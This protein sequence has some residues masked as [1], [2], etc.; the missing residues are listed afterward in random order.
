MFFLSK[1]H[2]ACALL[3]FVPA[4]F[5]GENNQNA[6]SSSGFFSCI[7][8]GHL[9]MQ[10]GY[11]WSHQGKS[12][13]INIEGLIGDNFNIKSHG[14]S[15]GFFGLG[16]FLKGIKKKWVELDYGLNAFYLANTSVSGDV[17]Q[18]NLFTNLSYSYEL[19]HYPIYASVESRFK[20]R[21]SKFSVTTLIGLGVNFIWAHKF[22]EHPLNEFT[23]ADNIFASHT[24]ASF[25]ATG[26][27][28]FRNYIWHRLFLELGYRFFYLGQGGFDK[29]SSLIRD[30]LSTG[31]CYGNSLI[32]SVGF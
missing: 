9:S 7:K 17:E 32:L 14:D 16:Y 8:E 15:N 18:E 23:I 5:F 11:Y 31:N 29:T 10:V 21:N 25:S 26:G 30:R 12:Q 19:A 27:L 20:I 24:S 6:N 3:F 13:H 4:F 1:K 22:K 2:L 28:G